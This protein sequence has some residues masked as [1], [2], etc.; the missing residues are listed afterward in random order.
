MNPQL[1]NTTETVDFAFWYITIICLVMLGA[2]TV[3]MIYFCIRYHRSRAPRPTSDAH[4]SLFL[5]LTWTLIP[6]LIVMSMFWY[7]WSGYMG[8]RNVPEG[9]YEITAK[10]RMWGWTFVY[11]SG[12]TASKMV[13]P[14]GKPVKVTIVA[15]DV[16]HGLFIPAFRVKKDAIPGRET[17]LWFS[18]RE[19]GSY[20]LFCTEYC[21]L[22]HSSMIST[23]EA[24][25]EEEFATWLTQKVEKASLP[26][27]EVIEKYG[28]LGCHSVDGTKRTGPTFKGLWGREQAVKRGGQELNLMV[29][30]DYLR[31]SILR[32]NAEI[33]K[34]YPAVMPVF[35]GRITE[36]ELNH[37]MTYL[38][39]LR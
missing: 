7:G 27:Q 3:A 18:A 4:G 38:E 34:G 32:S 30:S 28:C 2:I 21:G 11:P 26:G 23:V 36:D 24:I 35:E 33:V 13:V 29:D 15:E 39:K 37:L 14:V 5:E 20:D 16:L 25:P 19:A 12:K 17:Q 6:T 31:R 9:A 10:A 8:L 1:I 22:G